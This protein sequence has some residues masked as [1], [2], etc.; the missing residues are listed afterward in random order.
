MAGVRILARDVLSH[1]RYLLEKITFERQRSDGQSQTISREV[2][3]TGHGAV[4]L[5]YDPARGRVVLVK[6]FRL[7]VYL[8]NGEAY[9]IEAVAGKLEGEDPAIRIVMEVEEEAGFKIAKPVRLFEAFMSPGSFMEKL[10]FFIARYMPEDRVSAGGGLAD[11][12][13]DIQVIEPTLDE[14]LAMIETGEII[15][16]KTIALLYYAKINGLMNE[17]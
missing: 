13:E 14:A 12:G 17:T 11:E 16:V 15:D 10:S 2:F 4:I 6:Q 9:L 1:A 8:T 3:D 7:P 5:L